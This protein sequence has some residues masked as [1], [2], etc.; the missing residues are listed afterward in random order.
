LNS[1][2]VLHITQCLIFLQLHEY[3]NYWHNAVCRN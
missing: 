1:A 2:S 3:D